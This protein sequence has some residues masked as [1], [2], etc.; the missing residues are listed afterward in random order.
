MRKE[1]GEEEGGSVSSV[2]RNPKKVLEDFTNF[3]HTLCEQGIKQLIHCISLGAQQK[4]SN[5]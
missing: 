5:M 2:D 1:K 4:P 3:P